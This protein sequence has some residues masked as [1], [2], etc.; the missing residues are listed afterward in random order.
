M[1]QR[2]AFSRAWD[3]LDTHPLSK[4]LARFA[5]VVA[6]A[7]SV[8]LLAVLALFVDL[9]I[10]QGKVPAYHDLGDAAKR[11]FVERQSNFTGESRAA[12][13]EALGATGDIKAFEAPFETLPG[14]ARE[15]VWRAYVWR[16]LS[17]V[18]G[19]A[20]AD[21]YATRAKALEI[22]AGVPNTG[23]LSLV[24]RTHGF[25]VNRA[26]GWMARWN[27]WTWN[28]A[29]ANVGYLT[30]LLFLAI[31]FALV[32]ASSLNA[33]AA[34]AA[35][36]ALAV[37][38]WL[39]RAIYHQ[40]H[41]IGTLTLR[42]DSSGDAGA[43]FNRHVESVS[44][45]VEVSLSTL[46]YAPVELVFLLAFALLIH[47]W[48]AMAFLLAVL[49]MLLLGTQAASNFRRTAR[50]ADRRATARMSLLQESLGMMRL[51]KSN[52]MDAFNQSRV[53]R[54]LG[55]YALARQRKIR[56]DALFRP[57]IWFFGVTSVAIL[58][59]VGGRIVLAHG[60]GAANVFVLAATFLAAYWP[61]TAYVR[62]RRLV[63][64]GQ[65]SAVAIYEFLDRPREV[66]QTVGAEFLAGVREGIELRDVT[67]RDAQNGRVLLD[68]VNLT[69]AAGERV[70]LVGLDEAEKHAIVNLIARFVDP[71]SGEVRIDGKGL[72]WL[73]LESLHAQIG[74]VLQSNLLFNDTVAHNIGCGDPSYSVAQIIEAAKVAHAHHFVQKLPYGYETPVGDLG[75]SLRPGERLRIALARAI[76]RDPAVYVIEEPQVPLD[77]E[78]KSLLEDTFT[79][80]LPGKTVVFLPHRVSTIRSCD[81][82][83]LINRGHV[84]AVGGHRDLIAQNGLYRHLHYIEFNEYGEHA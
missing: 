48:L 16:H 43:L 59:Y 62:R 73:T 81:R 52:Q 24:A 49:I 28:R 82:L 18:L 53:E 79:R 7:A 75:T 39:R 80:V 14:P 67:M 20:A 26:I 57:L 69:I 13:L 58:L 38:T 34:S 83:Y 36:A 65:E 41:R 21:A 9:L 68:K 50:A 25:G 47:F 70:G 72:R 33:M 63:G 8:A 11:A 12:A 42:S 10:S 15:L 61:V 37:S 76:L 4:W 32:R 64:R 31:L 66:G 46:V 35:S 22:S 40:S 60:L 23:L 71:T 78:T 3:I 5:A 84:E 27:P 77:D 44:D 45:A 2:T 29:N 1:D 74:F 17:D 51:V 54:Q 6:A 30:G 56:G 55:E 19:P